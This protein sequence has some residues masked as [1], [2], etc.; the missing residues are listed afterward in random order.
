[1]PDNYAVNVGAPV[2]VDAYGRRGA[3]TIINTG[4]VPVFCAQQ[5]SPFNGTAVDAGG[6]VQW[7]KQTPLFL[8]VEGATAG[9]AQVFDGVA[10]APVNVNAEVTGTVDADVTGTV[11]VSAIGTPVNV[12]GGGEVLLS[13]S[14]TLTASEIQYLDIPAPSNGLTYY[15]LEITVQ[16]AT[17][18]TTPELYWAV[19]GGAINLIDGVIANDGSTL[20][21]STTSLRER[22][23]TPFVGAYPLTLMLMNM[24]PGAGV[25]VEFS[26]VGLSAAYP[27]PVTDLTEVFRSPLLILAAGA[28]TTINLPPSHTPYKVRLSNTGA[29]STGLASTFEVGSLAFVPS[30]YRALLTPTGAGGLIYEY[31]VP[32]TGHSG[33]LGITIAGAATGSVSFAPA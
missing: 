5:S 32:P 33:T 27:A 31:V 18:S 4:A 10:D 3:L 13:D 19:F 8:Y 2:Q 14:A 30:A 9:A 28:T 22:V 11:A 15:G 20:L 25:G 7:P 6:S 23:I 21:Y 16:V 17:P 26:V 29:A 12:Q 24:Q 1:M